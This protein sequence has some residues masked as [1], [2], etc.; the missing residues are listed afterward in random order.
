MSGPSGAVAEQVPGAEDEYV[1]V[2][3]GIMSKVLRG[4][5]DVRR[6]REALM[7]GDESTHR[8]PLPESVARKILDMA[9]YWC[10][11]EKI[12]EDAFQ[13]CNLTY[14]VFRF[15]AIPGIPRIVK[16]RITSHD[17]GWSSFPAAQGTDRNSWTF[18]QVDIIDPVTGR[19]KLPRRPR[20][21]TNVHADFRWK[22]HSLEFSDVSGFMTSYAPGDVLEFY[23]KSKFPGWCIYVRDAKMEVHYEPLDKEPSVA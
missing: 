7:R 13:G 17:Q 8:A 19:S 10:V 18:G 3:N 20:V 11:A 22:T 23:C 9:E 5:G 1:Q 16:L 6:L 4:A 14:R 12:H 15:G 2:K 21:F